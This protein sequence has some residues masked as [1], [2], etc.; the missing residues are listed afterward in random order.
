MDLFLQV[1]H[2]IVKYHDVFAKALS[3]H[4]FITFAASALSAVAGLVLGIVITRIQALRG[5]VIGIVSLLYTIPALSL[6][7]F[8]IPVMGIG[9]APAIVA[10]FIYGLLPVVQNTYIG[11]EQVNPA[12]IEAARGMGSTEFQLLTKVELP[13]AFPVIFGGLKNM[14]V[15]N[16]AIATI[17][18]FVGAG[19]MGDIIMKGIR[20][21]NDVMTL[22][23]TLVIALATILIERFFG[24]F[25]RRLNRGKLSK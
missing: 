12:I 17:A 16:V 22:S 2:F 1:L 11:I 21:F 15:M 18:V 23:G 3:Q 13:L 5:I 6:F 9:T 19:G 8:L 4:A 25:D 14:V 10:M 7:F 24:I 20:T